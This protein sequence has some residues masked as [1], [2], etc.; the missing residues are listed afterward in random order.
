MSAHAG[1][2]DASFL[3]REGAQIRKLVKQYLLHLQ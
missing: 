2:K 1:A 3:S